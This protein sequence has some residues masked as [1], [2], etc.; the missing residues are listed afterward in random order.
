[1]LDH[2]TDDQ[3]RTLKD[4]ILKYPAICKDIPGRT[5]LLV[6]EV[7]VG[8]ASPIKQSPYRLNP[9][10]SKLV[11]KEIDYMLKHN[12]ITPS[13]SPWSSP[14]VLVKK[15][16]GQPRLCFDYRKVNKVT[17]HDSF[18]LPR[19][20]DCI[21]RIGNAMFISKLDLLKGYWQ[22]ALSP[23]AQEISAFITCDG[24]YE[25]KVMPFGMRN[26]AATFQ[27]LMTL[28][29]QDIPGCAVYIDDIVISSD[30]WEEH[31]D[32]LD[33]VF[34]AIKNAGLVINIKKCEF[35]KASVTYLGHKIGH[36]RIAPKQ[37]NVES[38][39]K[40]PCPKNAREVKSFLGL[41]G[42]YRRFVQNFSDIVHP[43]TLLLKK[44][45]KFVW[46]E[47]CDSAFNKIKAVI[48][49]Y[50]ILRSPDFSKPFALAVD[51]SDYGVGAVLFQ[52]FDNEQHPVAFFS[53]K[54]NAAQQNYSTIEK[55]ALSLVLAYSHFE[56]YL[57]SSKGPIQVYTDHNPL[58][59]INK[60]RGKNARLTRWSIFFQDKNLEIHH[61]KGSLNVV[62]DRL[63]RGVM[64]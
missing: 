5:D 38:I 56:I 21:D 62:P 36:G 58:T 35:A 49:S 34:E 57:S 46:D 18:P 17:R 13:K 6:H 33:K 27:R 3:R 39:L 47:A 25:C 41:A 55:E 37:S 32:T 16:D 44:K 10:K 59:F 14:V 42:Y 15:E 52:D 61:I 11:K 26:S 45:S 43:L 29:L 28:I 24:L 4:L 48:T 54:L 19:I 1:M 12:L 30:S 2:L 8:G 64:G 53:K 60:F 9:E 51:A 23:Q 20:D 22:V 31:C 7:D 50:P 40:F 63:S